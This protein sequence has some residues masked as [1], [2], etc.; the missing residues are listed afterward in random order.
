MNAFGNKQHVQRT[1]LV[2]VLSYDFSNLTPGSVSGLTRQSI[3]FHQPTIEIQAGS[4]VSMLPVRRLEIEE[5]YRGVEGK[6][7]K[8]LEE[9]KE[10][11]GIW[12]GWSKI[13]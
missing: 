10:E 1:G 5:R 12:H 6:E 2:V 11:R 4:R 3:T 7:M 9:G 13:M 8:R